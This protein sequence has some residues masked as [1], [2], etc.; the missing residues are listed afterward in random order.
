MEQPEIHLHPSVQASLADLLLSAV[1][2]R[3]EGEYRRVQFIV[4]SHSEHLL[5]RLL[6]R[7]AEEKADPD[8]IALYFCYGGPQGSRIQRLEV[9][10]FGDVL[11][12]PED[13]FGDELEDV[14]EQAKVGMQRRLKLPE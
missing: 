8:D 11:N 10:E 13:L 4:E 12:W 14:A 1:S 9:D 6:R 3:E 2:S 7:V 5:R